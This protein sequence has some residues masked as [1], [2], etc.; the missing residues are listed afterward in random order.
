LSLEVGEVEVAEEAAQLT[1]EEIGR[2]PWGEGSRYPD[3]SRK[4]QE[5]QPAHDPASHVTIGESEDFF[6]RPIELFWSSAVTL[7]V[8]DQM[9]S[10]DA[11]ARNRGDMPNLGK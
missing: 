8:H 2:R 5:R 3:E 10:E 11:P 1:L 6:R 4:K 7:P 9:P